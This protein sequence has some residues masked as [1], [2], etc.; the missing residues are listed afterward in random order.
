[1]HGKVHKY[2]SAEIRF[3]GMY[4]IEKMGGLELLLLNVEWILLTLR[5][6]PDHSDCFMKMF[7]S[8][9]ESSRIGY[10]PYEGYTI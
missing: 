6:F 8:I 2:F 7:R 1:M 9:P 3:K 4:P 5:L 10:K